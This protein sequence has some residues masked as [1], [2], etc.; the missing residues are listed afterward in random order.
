MIFQLI[1]LVSLAALAFYAYLQRGRSPIVTVI[2][3]ALSAVGLLL[4]I[5]PDFANDIAH[6]MGIG[7]G[8]DLLV[9]CFILIT[10]AAIL[11]LHLRLRAQQDSLTTIARALT[12]LAAEVSGIGRE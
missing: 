5:E 8:A 4:T 3:F 6:F 10:F 7:R 12:L 9:Y 2:V 11:N 1:I